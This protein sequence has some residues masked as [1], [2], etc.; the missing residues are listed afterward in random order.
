MF[1]FKYDFHF[2]SRL[3]FTIQISI[4]SQDLF[5]YLFLLNITKILIIIRVC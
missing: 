1:L 3:D 2:K 4:D 5:P